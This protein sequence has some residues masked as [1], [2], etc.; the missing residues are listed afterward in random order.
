MTSTLFSRST[1]T[2]LI[3]TV[4]SPPMPDTRRRPF[5]S[6]SV[7]LSPML[8]RLI[9]DTPLPNVVKLLFARE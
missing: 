7:R 8:R 1:G 3:S 2:L 5:T 9:V 6:T 4:E